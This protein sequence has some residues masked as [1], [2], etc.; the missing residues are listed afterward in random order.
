MK[1]KKANN[2]NM[3]TKNGK[4]EMNRVAR[5]IANANRVHVLS[6]AGMSAESGIDTFR[7]NGGFWKGVLG[8][9]ALAYFGTPVGWNWR[10][11]FTATRKIVVGRQEKKLQW[12]DGLVRVQA[13][14][15]L[16]D[17]RGQT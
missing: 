10:Y 3:S 14:L 6:G 2:K 7:G 13:I 8:P 11:F 17:S 1:V 15:L 9:L 16:S 12:V 4:D 5:M